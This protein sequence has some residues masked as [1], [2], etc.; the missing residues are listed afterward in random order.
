[1]ADAPY[2]ADDP[3]AVKK[4]RTKAKF[5][6]EQRLEDWRWLL[7]DQRGRRIVWALLE[8]GG[9]FR[10]SFDPERPAVTAFHEG[11]RNGGLRVLHQVMQADPSAYEL[12][13]REAQEH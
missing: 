2:N 5:A 1:M 12:M 9:V 13:A 8:D 7:G 10:S 11:Q 3:V 6:E 4:R